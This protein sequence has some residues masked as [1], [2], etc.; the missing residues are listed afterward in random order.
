[1]E[2][3][4][5]KKIVFHAHFGYQSPQCSRSEAIFSRIPAEDNSKNGLQ[6]AGMPDPAFQD[7]PS[8]VPG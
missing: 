3:C 8:R 5:F 1:M 7:L 2:A 4:Y 6:D